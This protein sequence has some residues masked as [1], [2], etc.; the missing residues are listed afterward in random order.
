MKAAL[1]R[2]CWLWLPGLAIFVAGIWRCWFTGQADPW[3]WGWAAFLLLTPAGWR[4]GR[5][6]W[7]L[8]IW[9]S[10]G[11]AGSALI[12]CTIAADRAPDFIAA[13]GFTVAAILPALG[14]CALQMRRWTVGASALVLAALLLWLGPAQPIAPAANRPTLAV[15]TGLPLFWAEPEQGAEHGLTDAPIVTVLRTRFTVMPMDD[16]VMLETSGAKRL[17]LAQPRALSPADLVAID[18]WVRR[19]GTALVLADPLLRWPSALPLGDRRR[20]PSASLIGPLLTHWGFHTD[21]VQN[22]EIRDVTSDGY[23][24]TMSGMQIFA[25]GHPDKKDGAIRRQRIGRGMV[26]LLGDA[27]LLDDRL[28]LADPARPLNPRAWSADTPARV[29]HWLG[30]SI[31]GDRRWVRDG[32]STILAV[33]W[34]LLAGLIWAI[35]GSIIFTWRHRRIESRTKGENAMA[36]PRKYDQSPT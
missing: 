34:A 5:R 2:F 14:G 13:G 33:R 25:G 24:V 12:F 3:L 15:I 1:G 18:R 7:A 19:G 27:D 17:L 32:M 6:G 28:W 31:P 22:G 20:A 21:H 26:L 35:L 29:A 36:D 8:P 23:L 4:L 30:A 10:M 11:A 9:T 16:P